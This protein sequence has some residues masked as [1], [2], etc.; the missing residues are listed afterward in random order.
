M[1]SG[2]IGR[3]NFINRG[4][5]RYLQSRRRR[6]APQGAFYEEGPALGVVR[7]YRIF[8]FNRTAMT[9][10]TAV[11]T[12]AVNR[13]VRTSLTIIDAP[14]GRRINAPTGVQAGR[15]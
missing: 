6:R 3:T 10:S 14:L 4:L 7:V 1:L 5:S 12:N 2:D 13:P 9:V 15:E 11:T 8:G